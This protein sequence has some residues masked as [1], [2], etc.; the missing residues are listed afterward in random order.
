M[1]VRKIFIEI[2]EYLTP[3]KQEDMLEPYLPENIQKDEVGNYY[4]I[5]GETKTMFTSHLDNY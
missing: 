5:I 2:T 1:D 3:Y 4:I